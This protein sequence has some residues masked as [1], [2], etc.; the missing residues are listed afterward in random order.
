LDSQNAKKCFWSIPFNLFTTPSGVAHENRKGGLIIKSSESILFIKAYNLF[1][2]FI[3]LNRKKLLGS[4]VV[5][6]LP[7]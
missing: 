7:E 6:I 4:L 2:T 3:A 1:K 5:M